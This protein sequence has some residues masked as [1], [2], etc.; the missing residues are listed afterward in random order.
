MFKTIITLSVLTIT[1][2]IPCAKPKDTSNT[3]T[4]IPTTMSFIQDSQCPLL[5]YYDSE[6]NQCECL[7][8]AFNILEGEGIVFYADDNRGQ[9]I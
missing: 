2:V 1:T 8:N 7:S 6:N 9:L 5:F 3:A 4:I